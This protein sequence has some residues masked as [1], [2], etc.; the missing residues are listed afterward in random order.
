MS[1]MHAPPVRMGLS[2]DSHPNSE[3]GSAA[4]GVFMVAASP[5]CWTDELIVLPAGYLG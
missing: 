4:Y 1:V 3:S 5:R 2:K